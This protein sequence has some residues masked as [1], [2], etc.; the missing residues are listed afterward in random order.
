MKIIVAGYGNVGSSIAKKLTQEGHDVTV[1]DN[2]EKKIHEVSETFDTMAIVGSAASLEVLKDAG[3]DN[4]D[5]LIA[6]TD[7]DERNLLSC[8]IAKKCGCKNTIARVRNPELGGGIG[9]IKDDLKLSL[10]VNP[11]LSVAEEIAR[12][13]KFPAAIEID[14]FAK[15]KVELL[16]FELTKESPL[17]GVALKDLPKE[18]KNK[19]LIC[20]VERGQEISIPSGDF[21][22]MEGDKISVVTAPKQAYGFF[23]EANIYTGKARNCMIIGGGVT[24][25]YLAEMLLNEGVSVKIVEKNKARC[26]YLAERLPGAIVIWG[27]GADKELLAEEGVD[28]M[29]GFVSLTEHDEENVMMSIYC[30]KKSPNAKVITKVH[31]SAYD[32]IITDLNIGSIVNPKLLTAEYIVKYVRSTSNLHSGSMEALYMISSGKAEAIE[33]KAK[34][35]ARITGIYLRDLAIK[36]NVL[37][38]CIIHN[39]KVEIPNGQSVIANGDSVIVVTT[40]TGFDELADILK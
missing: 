30:K 1:I 33:F 23:K 3:I 15:E 34:E 7:S 19:T 13:L 12:L 35:D 6:V 4:A 28:K 8:L 24:S 18:I 38:A 14:T 5:L 31:R 9:I 40:E 10:V 32:E 22:L 26:D 11:E 2:N 16:K 39:K 36:D 27:D 21:V 25:V 17:N 20:I 29:D 37:V